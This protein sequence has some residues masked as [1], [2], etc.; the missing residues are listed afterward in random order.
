MLRLLVMVSML[1]L[2][3]CVSTQFKAL[4]PGTVKVG[5]MSVEVA[6]ASWNKAPTT[7]TWPLHSGSQLWTRDGLLLDYLLLI[8]GVADG[9]TLFKSRSK[10][11]VFPTYK[12][13]MLPNEIV[14]LTE[15]SV[16]KLYGTDMMVTSS[17]LRPFALGEQKA[18]T[19]DLT[20]TS[21]EGVA[22]RG[23]A[24]AFVQDQELYLMLYVGTTLH[25]FDKHWESALATMN[26]ARLSS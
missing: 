19:F 1:G 2:G 17:G 11:L 9:R 20:L 5:D 26:T 15:S 7:Q 25:Y 3:G 18:V 23:R 8:P 10:F 21:V 6:D 16:V 13:G 14:E 24:V 4:A 22:R 12:A